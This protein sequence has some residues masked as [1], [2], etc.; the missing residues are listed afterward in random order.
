VVRLILLV[1]LEAGLTTVVVTV[2]NLQKVVVA[3]LVV[4][5]VMAVTA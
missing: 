3:V 1:E 4:T 5:Q 2:A